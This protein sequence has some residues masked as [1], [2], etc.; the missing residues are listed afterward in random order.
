[1]KYKKLA[2]DLQ[3]IYEKPDSSIPISSVQI[4]INIGSI[5][6]PADLKGVTHFIEHMCLKGTAH[7]PDFNKVI[8]QYIDIGATYNAYSLQNFTVFVVKCQ[9]QFLPQCIKLLAEELLHSNFAL[10]DFKKEEKVV[11]EE[12]IIRSDNPHIIME[13]MTNALV[14]E[15]TPFQYPVDDITYHKKNY[16]YQTVLDFYKTHYVP[17]N[18]IFSVTSNASFTSILQNLKTAGFNKK[19]PAR[20]LSWPS[21]MPPRLGGVKYNLKHMKKLNSIFLNIAFQTCNQLNTDKYILNFFANIL[22]NS[23]S[24]R[25]NKILRQDHGLVYGIVATTNYFECGGNFTIASQFNSVS[26]IQKNKP[27]VLPLIIKELNHLLQDGINQHELTT[28]KH[29][30]RGRILMDL[31]NSDTQ[32]MYNGASLLYLSPEEIVPYSKLY[33]TYYEPITKAQVNAC[34]RKYFSLDRMSVSVLGNA[35]PPL[36]V[37]AAEC[38]NLKN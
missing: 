14:Y 24:S 11:V 23:L 29:N 22:C 1:M 4:F 38:N 25:L 19:S 31:E 20:Q 3:V 8:L 13:N 30:M 18:M 21:I 15:N 36:A 34:I 33:K 12:N 28:F 17:S 27:S 9:D 7:H 37:I 16:D 10:S 32:T 26:L 5:H 6:S 2:N 35:I